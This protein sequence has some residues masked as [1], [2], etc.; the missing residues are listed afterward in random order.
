M[1]LG[2]G[3]RRALLP[4]TAAG[5]QD[6]DDLDAKGPNLSYALSFT[7][8]QDGLASCKVLGN[9]RLSF[10]GVKAVPYARQEQQIRKPRWAFV[11][12]KAPS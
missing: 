3:L 10:S 11:I 1:R 8:S 6:S 2:N 12:F 7:R 9:A 4:H 5:L